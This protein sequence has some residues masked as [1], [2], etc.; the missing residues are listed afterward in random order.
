M[1]KGL[2]LQGRDIELLKFLSQYKTITLDNTKY[3]FETKTYQEKRICKLVQEN[4]IK[5]LPHREISLGRKGIKYFVETGTD[6]KE[7]CRSSNNLERL[8]IISDIAAFTTIDHNSSFIPSWTFKSKDTPTNDSRRYLGQLCFMREFYNVYSFYEGKNDK[9]I[10]SISYD[11]KKQQ[12]ILNSIIFTTD[13]DKIL[14]HKKKLG[15]NDS[16]LYVIEYNEFNKKIFRNYEKIKTCI[17]SD[18]SKEHKVEYTDFRHM[19]Y[20]IDDKLY[21]KLILFWDINQ[22]QYLHYFFEEN[23]SLKTNYYLICFKEFE[24]Y[25]QDFASN[26]KP[27]FIDKSTIEGYLDKDYIEYNGIKLDYPT[28]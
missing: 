4:Y 18:L 10:T 9:Y 15:F 27:I 2:I 21:F 19:D 8:K 7:H 17:F 12:S 14:Y 24:K 25:L 16:H 3:I 23:P 22:I 1:K 13:L 20:L 5:R 11:L 6:I 26:C 28:Y